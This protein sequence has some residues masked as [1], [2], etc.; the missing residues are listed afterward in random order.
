MQLRQRHPGTAGCTPSRA[1]D[2]HPE[3]TGEFQKR[4][5]DDFDYAVTPLVFDLQLKVDPASVSGNDSWKVLH[6]YG[7]PNPNSTALTDN[8]T[9]IQASY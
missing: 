9:L 2:H 7:S 3:C 8:G 4:L 5:A 6:V 1:R